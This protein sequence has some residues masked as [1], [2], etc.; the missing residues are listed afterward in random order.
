MKQIQYPFEPK[1]NRYM[2]A[3]QFW[4][5]L[6]NSGKFAC[7]RVLQIHPTYNR[8]FLGALMDWVENVLRL[9]MT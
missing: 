3:G 5:I 2:K 4:G 1:S 9:P 8:G 7:G 6:L